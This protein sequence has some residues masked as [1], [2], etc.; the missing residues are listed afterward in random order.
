[1]TVPE[2]VDLRGDP[3]V[4]ADLE[5]LRGIASLR[6]G[7]RLYVHAVERLPD[8]SYVAY[9]GVSMATDTSDGAG[10]NEITFCNYAP[11]GAMYADPTKID[12]ETY[13]EVDLPDRDD[14]SAAIR[15]RKRH[16]DPHRAAVFPP[17]VN[18]LEEWVDAHADR[19]DDVHRGMALAFEAARRELTARRDA[20]YSGRKRW[21]KAD[22]H[23]AI[24]CE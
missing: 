21:S 12:G 2:H 9:L 16:A 6:L 23:E 15:A 18:Q 11:V 8:G 14:V 13:Y 1:M 7:N 22:L 24:D 17:V 3:P 5:K 4:I 20:A 10:R 19:D